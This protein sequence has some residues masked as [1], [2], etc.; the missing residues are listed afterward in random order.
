METQ[1]TQRRNLAWL[2]RLRWGSIAGQ[3]VVFFAG[4]RLMH[5]SLPVLGIA[6]VVG[7]QLGSN[8]GCAL[9]VRRARAVAPLALVGVMALDTLLL[10]ALLFLAGGD[11]H[12]FAVLYLVNIALAG[13]LARA[14]W[15]WLLAALSLGCF[16]LVF[17]LGSDESGAEHDP[18]E[19][20]LR[21]AWLAFGV[22]SA[23]L[24]Y[25][26]Q[27]TTRMLHL[28][29]AAV[30]DARLALERREKLA[31]LA[32]LAAGA[33][34]ELGT[35]LSTI[36]LV[37]KELE[38]QLER[39]SVSPAAVADAKLIREEVDRCRGI[40]AQMGAEA[41]ASPGEAM[42]RVTVSALLERAVAASADR[43]RIQL[44]VEP[45][46][47]ATELCLPA[48]AIA[49]ALHAVLSNALQASGD[50][51]VTLRAEADPQG[52]RIDVEDRGP[53]MD[54]AILARAGEPFFTTKAPGHGMG[55]GL[56]LTRSVIEQ[57]GGR[58]QLESIPARGTTAR[59][60]L[61]AAAASS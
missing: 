23:L 19:W 53:G 59:L 32:T 56:F 49:Q 3:L 45:S 18:V 47:A 5:L 8:V 52:V 4:D 17:T 34:H 10:T 14:R 40:L 54:A 61:P 46:V 2:V 28:R 35:P 55:L 31:S 9:W 39:G 36:A 26:L 29:E 6:A 25:F 60:V 43:H 21:E 48:R 30:E 16:T 13:M 57:L 41:G 42:E 15:T 51:S 37:A 12:P 50:A 33:A 11:S 24:V 38:H 22:S 58:F 7:V 27:R 20:Q 1:D 44:R